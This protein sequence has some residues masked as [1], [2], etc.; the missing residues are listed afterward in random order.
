[1]IVEVIN[2][3]TRVADGQKIS[4]PCTDT[5]RIRA[6]QIAD[7]RVYTDMSPFQAGAVPT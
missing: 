2:L 1:V 6:G 5:Y 7:G 3:F 4:F